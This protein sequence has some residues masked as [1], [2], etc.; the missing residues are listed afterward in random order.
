[1]LEHVHSHAW[2]M[3]HW[4]YI[5]CSNLMNYK[6]ILV[7]LPRTK[8]TTKLVVYHSSTARGAAKEVIGM[9]DRGRRAA[10]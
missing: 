9:A 8:G 5:C 10:H 2:A 1:M 6:F 3:R 7:L 4:L